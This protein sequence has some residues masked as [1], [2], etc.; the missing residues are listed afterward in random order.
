MPHIFTELQ[1]NQVFT[2]TEKVPTRAFSWLKAPTSVPISGLPPVRAF[3][4]IVKNSPTV[5]LQLYIFPSPAPSSLST[6][7]GGRVVKTINLDTRILLSTPGTICPKC[8]DDL[9]ST[10]KNC[11]QAIIYNANDNKGHQRLHNLLICKDLWSI[12]CG[13]WLP[14]PISLKLIW[15]M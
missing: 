4:V 2:I 3:S 13:M 9:Q 1:T 14:R 10:I 6:A 5:R 15:C 11:F 12:T 7:P 8:S